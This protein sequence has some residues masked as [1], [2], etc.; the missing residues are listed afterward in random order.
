MRVAKRGVLIPEQVNH[1]L[2]AVRW[3]PCFPGS[4]TAVPFSMTISFVL[5]VKRVFE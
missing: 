2:K 1:L 5:K 4:L 3:H